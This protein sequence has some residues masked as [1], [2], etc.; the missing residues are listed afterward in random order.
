MVTALR[1]ESVPLNFLWRVLVDGWDRMITIGP[2][3]RD[4]Y[5]LEGTVFYVPRNDID[6][7]A[8]LYRLYDSVSNDHMVSTIPGEL[9]YATESIV[10]YPWDWQSEGTT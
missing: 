10:G 8:P 2:G 6:D 7:T 5:P 9:G 1:F 3:E 4:A